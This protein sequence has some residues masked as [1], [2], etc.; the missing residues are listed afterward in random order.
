MDGEG[1]PVLLER[2]WMCLLPSPPVAV[3]PVSRG[4][5]TAGLTLARSS[6]LPSALLP[7][8]QAGAAPGRSIR[9]ILSAAKSFASSQKRSNPLGPN[10]LLLFCFLG[11]SGGGGGKE[12]LVSQ[13]GQGVLL[14]AAAAGGRDQAAS[15]GLGG[16]NLLAFLTFLLL[17]LS[18]EIMKI[19]SFSHC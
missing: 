16:N 4:V 6:D 1:L 18:F 17:S 10:F 2:C 8:P 13:R 7:K 19:T 15:L 3:P 12:I 14:L 9:I 5:L 11:G